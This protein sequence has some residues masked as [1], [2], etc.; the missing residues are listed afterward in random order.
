MKNIIEKIKD[1]K[2]YVSIKK[3]RVF[4]IFTKKIIAKLGL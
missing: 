4:L 1:I 2:K 3:S